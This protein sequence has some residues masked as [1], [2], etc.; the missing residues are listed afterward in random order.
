M[1]TVR[2]GLAFAPL[3]GDLVADE[4]EEGAYAG[5]RLGGSDVASTT[6]GENRRLINR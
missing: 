3:L 5:G 4:A 1:L 2:V 6:S